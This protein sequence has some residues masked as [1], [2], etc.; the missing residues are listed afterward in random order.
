MQRLVFNPMEQLRQAA[1]H[2]GEA[3]FDYDPGRFEPNEIGQVAQAFE[4]MA[5][6]VRDR[7]AQVQAK[8]EALLAEVNERKNAEEALRDSEARFRLL[9]AAS[10]DAI[11][12][13]DP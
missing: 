9:F 6:R 5:L 12:L 2:V 11:M 3:D 7:E 1:E 8:A 13:I 4:D 10:P